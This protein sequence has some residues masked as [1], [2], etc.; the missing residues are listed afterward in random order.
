MPR[1]EYE[2]EACGPFEVNQKM[3]DPPLTQH[4]CGAPA[5]RL[6]SNTSFA[7]KGSG[8]YNDGYGAKKEKSS[9]SKTETK[10]ETKTETKTE[11]KPEPK[12]D[13]KP[14]TDNKAA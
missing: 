9:D 2:C 7:L 4:D 10:S 14:S 12:P 3:S 5:H 11:P 8:W 6:I 1:Y 13:P